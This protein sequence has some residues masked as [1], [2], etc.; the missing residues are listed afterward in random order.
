MKLTIYGTPE[1]RLAAHGESEGEHLNPCP[2]C[3]STNVEICN[4]HTPIY[5]VECGDC[6]A[7]GGP[8]NYRARR[9]ARTGPAL[10]AQHGRAFESARVA[11]NTRKLA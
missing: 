9:E 2:F 8:G 3:G 11:W 6:G 4:T 10:R 7:Q 5:W 1:T